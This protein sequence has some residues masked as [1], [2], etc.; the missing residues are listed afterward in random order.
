MVRFVAALGVVGLL[1]GCSPTFG[2]A[3]R[4]VVV[5][6]AGTTV[7]CQSGKAPPC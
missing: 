1:V 5:V 4:E 2:S 7:V 6:P 3:E